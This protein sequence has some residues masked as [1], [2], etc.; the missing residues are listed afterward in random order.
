M[1]GAAHALG[2]LEH[3]EQNNVV[4]MPAAAEYETEPHAERE[5]D[6]EYLN[7]VHVDCPGCETCNPESKTLSEHTQGD[8][9]AE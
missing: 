9:F 5:S 1:E 7:R 4:E 8:G 6:N 3:P 2:T